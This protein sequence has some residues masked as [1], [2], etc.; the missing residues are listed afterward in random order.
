MP[1]TGDFAVDEKRSGEV[2][3]GKRLTKARGHSGGSDG[4]ES[5]EHGKA[6][7]TGSHPHGEGP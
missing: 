3:R 5:S 1:N 6:V 2:V 7:Y 4:A